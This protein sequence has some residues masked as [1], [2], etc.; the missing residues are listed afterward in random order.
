[1]SKTSEKH[2][3]KAAVLVIIAIMT[4]ALIS[5]SPKGNYETN[6]YE[7]NEEFSNISISTETA[8]I[9]FVP[10]EDGK[11]KVVCYE[12]ENMKHS[13]SAANGVLTV[14][15]SEG[16]N[17]YESISLLSFPKITVYLPKA[18]YSSLVIN[19]STGDI[20]IPGNFRFESIDISVSTG[21]VK[22][23]ASAENAMKITATTGNIDVENISAASLMLSV[24]TGNVSASLV[25]T[26]GDITVGVST[27]KTKLSDVS[28]KNLI[29]NGSTGDISLENVIA[30]GKFSI[31]RSTG[32][33]K[34]EN[35]DAAEIFIETDTGDVKGSLLSEKIFTVDTDTG[36]KEFPNTH[37]G[38]RCQISTDTGD[39]KITIK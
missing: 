24:T 36:D 22:C 13:V 38:G 8:N 11:C 37:S 2:L 6:T 3:I 27:G 12:E 34:F 31:K 23:Y 4:S 15:E 35:S 9:V 10:S 32:D 16:G 29:S 28:C 39:I 25:N 1:M 18:N 5:C 7:L 20:E 17:W 33:V 26:H 21:N 19:E 14:S 30:S